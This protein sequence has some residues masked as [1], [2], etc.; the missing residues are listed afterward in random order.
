MR[1]NDREFKIE[2]SGYDVGSYAEQLSANDNLKIWDWQKLNE[3][4]PGR[5]QI[6]TCKRVV[7][8]LPE[9]LTVIELLAIAGSPLAKLMTVGFAYC[10]PQ[11]HVS[12][13]WPRALKY[14]Y[15]NASPTFASCSNS[16][17]FVWFFL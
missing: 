12:Y 9:P 8:H 5:F 6:I 13:F 14:A 15:G 10:A 17:P 2:A 3:L 16:L 7:E 4:A 1:V 11:I